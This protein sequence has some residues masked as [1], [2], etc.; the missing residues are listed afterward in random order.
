MVQTGLIL[1]TPAREDKIESDIGMVPIDYLADTLVRLANSKEA[2]SPRSEAL[3]LHIINPNSLPYSM[4]PGVIGQT[5]A[6]HLPGKLIDIDSWFDAITASSSEAAY[7]EWATYKEYLDKGHLMFTIGDRE[8]R[9][10]LE[11]FAA[12]PGRVKCHPIDAEYLGSI[13]MQ[14]EMFNKSKRA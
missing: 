5:R 14:D 4:A 11:E 1:Q 13:L 8:T 12:A 3:R 2:R 7:L 6:D 9:P 10:L